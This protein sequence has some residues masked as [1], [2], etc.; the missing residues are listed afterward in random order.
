MD[1]IQLEFFDSDK[2]DRNLKASVHKTG[3][4]GFTIDAAKKLK[5][6]KDKSIS[7]ARNKSDKSDRNLYIV[8]NESKADGAFNVNKAGN[9]YYINT[10]TLF[11]NLKIDYVSNYI[12]F[13]ISEEEISGTKVFLLKWK[14]K[15]RDNDND[16]NEDD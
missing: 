8:V 10:K 16:S 3:K 14:E 2:L 9:Y 1:I 12:S 5:L 7:I 6:N 11:D 15:V 13:D 4:I